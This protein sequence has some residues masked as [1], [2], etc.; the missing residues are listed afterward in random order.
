MRLDK[1]PTNFT[2]FCHFLWKHSW[3]VSLCCTELLLNE[4]P[5]MMVCKL[6]NSKLSRWLQCFRSSIDSIM[7][8]CMRVYVREQAFT[9]CLLFPVPIAHLFQKR[10]GRSCLC[11]SYMLTACVSSYMY[12]FWFS[13]SE[14]VF[15]TPLT[16]C[17]PLYVWRNVCALLMNEFIHSLCNS[18]VSCFWVMI[19]ALTQVLLIMQLARAILNC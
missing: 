18:G 13:P 14:D 2:F 11:G 1:Q 15:W 9:S 12:C 17:C 16:Q 10:L 3:H 4:R 5:C 6:C 8:A 7:C 19:E